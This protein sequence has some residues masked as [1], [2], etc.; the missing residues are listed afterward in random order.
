[1]N[2]SVL[3]KYGKIVLILLVLAVS[4]IGAQTAA[5]KKAQPIPDSSK[6]E[7]VLI[8]NGKQVDGRI[9]LS[10]DRRYIAIEDLATSLNGTVSY[11]GNE[12]IMNIPTAQEVTSKSPSSVEI[13]KGKIKGIL[14][15]YFNVNYGSKP[16]VGSEVYVV[17]S[18]F[19]IPESAVFMGF[20]DSFSVSVNNEIKK[21]PLINKTVADGTGSFEVDNVPPGKYTVVLKSKHAKGDLT[22]RDSNGKVL[23]RSVTVKP[24]E[25]VDGSC[26][27]GISHR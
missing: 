16:D 26:D 10:N 19:D 17:E 20:S 21:Y 11:R 8:V 24:G 3:S 2:K 27:F 18:W 13:S 9:I 6:T 25:T 23:L 7:K 12:I 14:T 4:G 1:M 22:L 5:K 15:Y